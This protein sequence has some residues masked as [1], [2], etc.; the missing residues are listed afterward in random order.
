L[1]ISEVQLASIG[2]MWARKDQV[3]AI[4]NRIYLKDFSTL[5]L[6]CCEK[7]SL[8]KATWGGKGFPDLYFQLTIH[9]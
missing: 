2:R 7:E 5:P 3:A 6:C 4:E 8:T 1:Q 9:P